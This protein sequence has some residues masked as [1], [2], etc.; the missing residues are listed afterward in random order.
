MWT[1]PTRSSS[2]AGTLI[3]SQTASRSAQFD[4]VWN[5]A[6]FERSPPTIYTNWGN[7]NHVLLGLSF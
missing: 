6:S 5:A 3:Q 4:V 2:T 7:Y 1:L